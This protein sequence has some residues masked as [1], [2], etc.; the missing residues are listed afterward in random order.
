[1]PGKGV[2]STRHRSQ[3]NRRD[4]SFCDLS[5]CYTECTY[6]CS[7]SQLHFDNILCRESCTSLSLIGHA[8][9]MEIDGMDP[10]LTVACGMDADGALLF[11]EWSQTFRNDTVQ[12]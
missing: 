10:R 5:P 7:A 6:A 8:S 3:A 2:L 9:S 12:H 11:R 1:M 4:S